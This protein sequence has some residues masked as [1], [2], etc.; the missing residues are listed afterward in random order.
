VGL[1]LNGI[2]GGDKPKQ[3]IK[4]KKKTPPSQSKVGFSFR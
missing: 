2:S 3:R 1:I 4:A